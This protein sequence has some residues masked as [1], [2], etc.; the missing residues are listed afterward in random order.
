[1]PG[2]F[3]RQ[4]CPRATNPDN[5]NSRFDLAELVGRISNLYTRRNLCPPSHLR[6]AAKDWLGLSQDE[7]VAVI[8]K[9]FDDCRRFYTS[10]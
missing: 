9:H 4:C 6:D 3:S 8:N 1:M 10:G 5:A 2:S 7:I